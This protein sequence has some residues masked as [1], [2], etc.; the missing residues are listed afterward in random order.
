MIRE[1]EKYQL[2]KLDSLLNNIEE[3]GRD[4]PCKNII[5]IGLRRSY[6]AR[7]AMALNHELKLED[8]HFNVIVWNPKTIYGVRWENS[9]VCLVEDWWYNKSITEATLQEIRSAI[10]TLTIN[11]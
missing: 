6:T 5:F 10:T 11:I 4:R 2:E 8:R 7:L 1:Q 3:M 9:I